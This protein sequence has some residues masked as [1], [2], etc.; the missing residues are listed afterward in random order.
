MVKLEISYD[1][2]KFWIDLEKDPYYFN[3]KRTSGE[4]NFFYNNIRVMVN[5]KNEY[6]KFLK[7]KILW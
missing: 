1:G 7:L 3:Q 6:Y 4:T 5:D 2:T